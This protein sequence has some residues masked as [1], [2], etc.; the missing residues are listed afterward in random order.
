MGGA[1]ARGLVKSE[2]CKASD[3]VA[4]AATEKTL[5]GIAEAIPGIVTSTSNVE[6]AEDADVII[7]AVKPW[8]IDEVMAEI[9]PV[10]SENVLLCSVAA[11]VSC[12]DL[13]EMLKEYG[14]P[15][16]P[17]FRVVPNTAAAVGESITFI[18]SAGAD[19][20]EKKIVE[21]LFSGIGEVMEIEEKKMEACTALAS[22]GIAFAMRYVRACMQAGVEMG[23]PAK[24]AAHIAELTMRGAAELLL[25]TGNHPEVEIDRVTTPGGITIKGVNTL[26]KYSFNTAVIEAH[27]ACL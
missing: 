6:A 21:G 10:L 11:G 25:H 5:K 27:K 7:L 9:A 13:Q 15:L 26:D 12:H 3:I 2:I 8:K 23:V 24:E 16:V 4:T 14:G 17:V 18:S 1:I 22:C 20:T 19:A